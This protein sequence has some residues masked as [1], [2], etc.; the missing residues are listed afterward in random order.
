MRKRF[1]ASGKTGA[2]E[3]FIGPVYRECEEAAE[4]TDSV[5]NTILSNL[6]LPGF[7]V[8]S[9]GVFDESD[10]AQINETR[11]QKKLEAEE[12]AKKAEE[13][14]KAAEEAARIEAEKAAVTEPAVTEPEVTETSETEVT[15]PE[16]TE[17]QPE[18][19]EAVTE[20]EVTEEPSAPV[21]PGPK[22]RYGVDI[23]G[24]GGF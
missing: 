16:V 12:A 15:E 21:L 1:R 6:Y 14:R 10:T 19:T 13:E 7:D 20:P 5:K 11:R 8:N 17:P 24:R 18:Q 23:A 2:E 9:D 3:T 4:K 22:Q